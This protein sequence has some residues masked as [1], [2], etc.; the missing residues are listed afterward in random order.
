MDLSKEEFLI[1]LSVHEGARDVESIYVATGYEV[2]S[3]RTLLA[4]L[5]KHGFVKIHKEFDHHFDEEI[6]KL[7]L[8]HKADS[9]IKTQSVKKPRSAL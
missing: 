9:V 4:N 5:D 3:I 6:W 8:T 1:L 2:E 7:S